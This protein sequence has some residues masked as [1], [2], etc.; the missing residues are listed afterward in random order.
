MRLAPDD[1]APSFAL[2]DRSGATHRFGAGSDSDRSLE[3]LVF[4]KHDC[5]TCELVIPVV[6]RVHDTLAPAGLLVRTV[7]QSAPA[8]AAAF[9]ARHRLTIPVLDDS[10]CEVSADYGIEI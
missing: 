5:A 4:W 10:A 2:V 1:V 3:L 7:T 6:Q 8:D 9:V